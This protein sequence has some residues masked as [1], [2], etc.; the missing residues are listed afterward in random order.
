VSRFAETSDTIEAKVSS[1]SSPFESIQF[2]LPFCTYSFSF[3]LSFFL[4]TFSLWH[5]H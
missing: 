2:P 3:F 4:D 1:S 5:W